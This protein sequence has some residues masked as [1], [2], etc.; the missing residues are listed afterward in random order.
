MIYYS[1]NFNFHYILGFAVAFFFVYLF[2]LSL[3]WTLPIMIWSVAVAI[4]RVALARHHILDVCGGFFV[5]ILEY[6]IM[7]VFWLNTEQAIKWAG[8]FTSAEDPWSGA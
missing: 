4:S 2:P 1:L 6:L 8:M 7:S 5:A 3:I